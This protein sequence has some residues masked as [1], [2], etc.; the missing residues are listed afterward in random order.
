MKRKY[1]KKAEAARKRRQKWMDRIKRGLVKGGWTFVGSGD[2]S[3]V[4]SDHPE[5]RSKYIT[6]LPEEAS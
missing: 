2:G 3:D 6:M 5:E 4:Q 1:K